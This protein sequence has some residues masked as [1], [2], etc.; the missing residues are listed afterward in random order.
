MIDLIFVLLDVIFDF[1]IPSL[2]NSEA[3]KNVVLI[4]PHLVIPGDMGKEITVFNFPLPDVAEIEDMMDQ[5]VAENEMTTTS[6]FKAIEPY[7]VY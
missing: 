6:L 5:I 4:S 1:L 3:R 7:E 2:H